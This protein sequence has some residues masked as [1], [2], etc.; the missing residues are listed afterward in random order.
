MRHQT[1]TNFAGFKA[2]RTPRHRYKLFAQA[3]PTRRN[4]LRWE[5]TRKDAIFLRIVTLGRQP[6]KLFATQDDFVFI[7]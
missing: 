3:R 7:D 6:R 2:T 5:Q 4:C 1:H